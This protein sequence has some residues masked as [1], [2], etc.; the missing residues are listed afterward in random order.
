MENMSRVER[1]SKKNRIKRKV[2]KLNVKKILKRLVKIIIRNS[3]YLVV[4][5]SYA[6]YLL[7]RGFDNLIAKLFMKLPRIMKVAIIYL[8]VINL[9]F[10]VYSIFEDTKSIKEV[11]TVADVVETQN[12][13][14][15]FNVEE[16]KEEICNFD[17][18][19][20]KIV[21][22][23]KKIGLNEEQTLI[24]I[25][26]SKWE[27]GNYTS[28][29]FKNKNNVGGMMCS[30]GLIYYNNLD[31]GINAFLNNLKNNY[32]D[33]GLDTLEKIQPKYCP[34]GASNDPNGLNQ[35]WLKGTNQKLIELKGK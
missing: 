30:S 35:Y 20:C 8:L 3:I 13:P 10:D 14:L 34:V 15:N 17:S 18:T 7:I 22:N 11:V 28:S 1:N 21:E 4:G 24:S 16:P 12:I 31:D 27:T 25:A 6:I 9:G 2:K 29:A 5:F 33:I 23:A 32:F 19:S 26:I